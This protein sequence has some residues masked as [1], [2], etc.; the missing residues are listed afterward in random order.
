MRKPA[1]RVRMDLAIETNPAD[2]DQVM[3][4][5]KAIEALKTA[6]KDLGFTMTADV[7][8]KLGSVGVDDEPEAEQEPEPS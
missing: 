5:A 2:I 4:S 3:A 7:T 6:A 8:A 1:M